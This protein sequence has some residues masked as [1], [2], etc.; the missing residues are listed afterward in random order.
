MNNAQAQSALGSVE[1]FIESL[2]QI[3]Q[4][5]LDRIT[6]HLSNLEVQV[7]P[8]IMLELACVFYYK[9][10]D[11]TDCKVTSVKVH[12]VLYTEE[13]C[14]SFILIVLVELPGGT[15]DKYYLCP[16]NIHKLK[17]IDEE[18]K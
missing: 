11:L 12:Q 8:E 1:S 9:D 15:I 13:E 6:S 10:C 3:K 2:S 7:T 17:F 16:D 18:S 4:R 5:E 14:I